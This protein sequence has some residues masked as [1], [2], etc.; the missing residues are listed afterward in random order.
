MINT[1][2]RA[3]DLKRVQKYFFAAYDLHLFLDTNPYNKEA[4]KMYAAM[5]EKAKAAQ[6]EFELKYG[7][8]TATS[9]DCNAEQWHWIEN[10]WPWDSL[11]D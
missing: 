2:N 6:K 1:Q 9:I 5:V 10:P 4:L 8:L 7:P 11:E 3:K